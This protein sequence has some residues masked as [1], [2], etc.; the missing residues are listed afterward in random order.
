VKHGLPFDLALDDVVI[1]DAC[2]VLG[3]KLETHRG[4]IGQNSPTIDR[5][6]PSLGYVRG[7]VAIIS[8]RAN[9]LKR[10]RTAAGN[11]ALGDPEHVAI[12]DWMDGLT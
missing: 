4:A 3:M 2:P 7:N 12:A 5:L 10:D 8:N 9:V 11:R 6:V 1:P